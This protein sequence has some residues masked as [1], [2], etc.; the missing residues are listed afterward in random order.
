MDLSIFKDYDIRGTY[1]DQLNAEVARAIA[2]AIVR[3]FK[4]KSIAICRDMRLSGRELRNSF[5]ETFTMLGVDVA[6]AGL[7]GTETAY[8]LAGTRDYDLVLMISAS[9]NPADY[10]GLKIVKKGPI[11]VNSDSG[12]FAVRDL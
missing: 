5:V 2:H 11:G 7:T 10:N 1:P 8:Y 3:F 12:L 6:D 4:P 9:H